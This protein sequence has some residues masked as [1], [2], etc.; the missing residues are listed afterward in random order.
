MCTKYTYY[1]K[2]VWGLYQKRLARNL[3]EC[4][5]ASTDKEWDSIK[6]AIKKATNEATGTKKK[7]RKRKG[8]RIWKEEIKNVI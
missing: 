6:T 3:N 5:E 1:K 2:K 8:L 7:H 4:S